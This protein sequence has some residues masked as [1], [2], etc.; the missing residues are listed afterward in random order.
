MNTGFKR[1]SLQSEPPTN[2]RCQNQCLPQQ[3]TLAFVGRL[4]G[5]DLVDEQANTALGDDVGHAV[6]DLHCNNCL[7]SSNPEHGKQIN[8]GVCAPAD[9]GDDLAEGDHAL[10]CGVLLT[11]GGISKANEQGVDDAQEDHHG[12]EPACPTLAQVAADDELSW[13]SYGDHRGGC[14]SKLL[15]ISAALSGAHLHG[16]DDLHEQQGPGQEPVHVS[17]S[18]V[19]RDTGE[20]G[21]RVRTVLSNRSAASSCGVLVCLTHVLC[22][23]TPC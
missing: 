7:S 6:T 1:S 21:V 17:V 5:G 11:G 9:D 10:H 18:I 15:A 19:E 2:C 4:Q 23:D 16:Q 14:D 3:A 8:H 20:L 22:V 12:E 13:V